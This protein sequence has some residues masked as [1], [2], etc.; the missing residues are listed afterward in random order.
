MCYCL[1]LRGE[2]QPAGSSRFVAG[3]KELL[4]RPGSLTDSLLSLVGT[5]RPDLE[6]GSYHRERRQDDRKRLEWQM[7]NIG[8]RGGHA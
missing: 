6:D 1:E 5:R 4:A 2:A 7:Q 3:G 8:A